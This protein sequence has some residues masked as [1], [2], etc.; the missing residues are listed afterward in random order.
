MDYCRCVFEHRIFRRFVKNLRARIDKLSRAEK[1]LI[2]FKKDFSAQNFLQKNI[3][4]EK[5]KVQSDRCNLV[6]VYSYSYTFFLPFLPKG[7][8]LYKILTSQRDSGCRIE[9]NYATWFIQDV[10]WGLEIDSTRYRIAGTNLILT[11]LN[12]KSFI[13]R[14][15]NWLILSYMSQNS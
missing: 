5:L 6:K 9:F 15:N 1:N 2:N 13:S 11:S 3:W 10:N 4:R 12:C 7:C 14:F 8:S